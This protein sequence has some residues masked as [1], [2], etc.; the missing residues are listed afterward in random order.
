MKSWGLLVYR[1]RWWVLII[2]VLTLVPAALLTIRGAYLDSVII[3]T[4]TTSSQAL[5]LMKKELPPTSPS[6]GLIFQSQSLRATD[7]IFKAEVERAVAP[8]RTDPQVSTVRTPYDAGVADPT[9]ISRDGQ[10]IIA[11]VELKDLTANQTVLAMDIYPGLRAKVHSN[12]LEVTAFGALPRNHDFTVL[13]ERDVKHA[14]MMVLPVVALLLILVF[15]S[16]LGAALPLAVGLLAVTAGMAGT[17]VLARFTPVLVFSKNVIVMVGLGVAIDYSLF[18]VSRFREEV[19]R[20]SVPDAL[21][22]TMATTGRAVLFSGGTVA[23]GLFSMLLLGLGVLGSMG[24]AGAIV[25]IMALF[26]AMTFL[27]AFLAILGSKV[28]ALKLPFI[29]SD[30]SGKG[31]GFWRALATMVMAHPWRVLLPAT[32]FLLVLGVPFMHIQ[33]GSSDVTGLPK[34][35][36][37]RRGW[38]LLRNE[39]DKGNDESIIVVVCFPD[40]TPLTPEHVGRIYDLSR[41]L[42][43]LPGIK[44]VESVV[45]LDPSITRDQYIQFLTKQMYKYPQG[46]QLVLK[47]TVGNDIIVLATQT[48]PPAGSIEAL[49]L[50]RTIRDEHPP[51]GGELMVTGE[52]AFHVDFIDTVPR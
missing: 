19:H 43:T 34:S 37:S 23:I 32:L 41:W 20:C 44:R 27:P 3:P 18:I 6:F 49:N 12:T 10:S 22:Y 17:L 51:V 50:V 14:E 38:E 48:L 29:N 8:L 47:K 46:L 4:N 5:N 13:A 39:F 31:G 24:L 11:E 36:E 2:S 45:D 9:L 40:S 16:V 21:A 30:N 52:S 7:P 1:F 28:D 25:V 15:G 26:Y 42:A 35:D 33:L